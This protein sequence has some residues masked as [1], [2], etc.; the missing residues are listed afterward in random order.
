MGAFRK[1]VCATLLFLVAAIS[2]TFAISDDA[3][4]DWSAPIVEAGRTGHVYPI[5]YTKTDPSAST[6][7]LQ[8]TFDDSGWTDGF[9][10][11]ASEGLGG[12]TL[13]TTFD[14]VHEGPYSV[15]FRRSFTLDESLYDK[16]VWLAC[17]HDDEG[18]IYIDG[19]LLV[20]W[21]NVWNAT[22]YIK[23]DRNQT[24][25][26]TKGNHVF[27]V[28]AKNNTGAFYFDCGL[29]GK[30]TVDWDVPYLASARSGVQYDMLYTLVRPSGNAWTMLDFD[31]SA[32]KEGKGPLGDINGPEGTAP[33][34]LRCQANGGV[35]N[36]WYRRRFSLAQDISGRE[37]WLACGHDDEGEIYIDGVKI[38]GWGNEWDY[39][40]LQNSQMSRRPFS[41]RE[42]T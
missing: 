3:V 38:A 13:G 33:L 36:V 1:R 25:Y 12:L 17:G 5:K 10:P 40:H 28:L 31:D 35:Y 21:E 27:S 4:V 39:A 11:I 8:T 32:W 29:Y 14:D 42:S 41:L 18:A 7:W 34:G 20:S 26:L 37:V 23:L 30:A 9:G 2:S 19:N 24:R 6:N 15:W 16:D 22:E